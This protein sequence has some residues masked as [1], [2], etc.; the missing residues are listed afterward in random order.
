MPRKP[1]QERSKA[2]YDA[3]VEAGFICVAERGMAGT[4]TRHIAD[5]AGIGVGSLYEYFAN[6]EEVFDQMTKQFVVEVV[7]MLQP[8]V[9]EL[10]RMSIGEA[11]KVMLQHF[12]VFLNRNDQRYLRCAREAMR[13]DIKDYM[14]PVTTVLTEIVMQHV[15]HHPEQ[16]RIRSIPAMSYIFINGGIFAV[17][18]HLSNPNPPITYEELTQGLA[19]M[20]DH[21]VVREMQ[22]TAPR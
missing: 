19:D 21:Y 20:V 14:Q 9:P 2:T 18:Q 15:L 1:K 11:I 3:I 5:T 8:L 6:K 10:A 4:T 17:V 13:V 16:M 7:A 22:L 12:E